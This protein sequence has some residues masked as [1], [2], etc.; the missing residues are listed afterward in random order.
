MNFSNQLSSVRETIIACFSPDE[1]ENNEL[2]IRDFDAK[3]EEVQ[4]QYDE[5]NITYICVGVGEDSS[6]IQYEEGL[7]LGIKKAI[8]LK[9]DEISVVVPETCLNSEIVSEIVVRAS[10]SFDKYKS[11]KSHRFTEVDVVSYDHDMSDIDKG[12][13]RGE[14][15]NYTRDLQNENANVV[16]PE[17]LINQCIDIFENNENFDLDYIEGDTLG[18][19]GLGL[20]EAVGRGSHLDSAL[21]ILKYNGDLCSDEYTAVVGKGVTFDSGGHS[22]KPS[23]AMLDMRMDMS[24]AASVL[25]LMKFVADAQPTENIIAVIPA[26]HNAISSTAF[27]VGDVCTSYSGKTV[28]IHNTDAEGRLILADA[29]SYVVKNYEVERVVDIATLTGAIVVA[30]GENTAGL[31]SNN[32]ELAE[33]LFNAGEDC[34]ERLWRMPLREEHRK[35]MKGERADLRNM[36]NIGRNCGSTTASAFLENF[37]D[38]TPWCHIDIA[39][40]AMNKKDGGTGFGT[41]LLIE[42]L[43]K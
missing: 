36:S 19:K 6:A 4:V 37:V 12:I 31:F 26:C 21:I 2:G 24:G 23:D 17:Y 9:R 13:C 43:V 1:V 38:D 34:N 15:I 18:K 39:G 16:T 35:A 7:A 33:E 27:N 28:E 14:A 11:E 32:D 22:L 3:A 8:E 41:G 20:L 5:N 42:W 30:L 40:T 29:L 10:Y 25:G